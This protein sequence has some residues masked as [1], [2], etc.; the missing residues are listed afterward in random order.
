MFPK[1]IL[2]LLKYFDMWGFWTES[3]KDAVWKSFIRCFYTIHLI[4]VAASTFLIVHLTL[5]QH[6][7]PEWFLVNETVKQYVLSLTYWSILIES[8]FGRETQQK[9]WKLFHQIQAYNQQKISLK[10]YLFKFIKH[11]VENAIIQAMLI[12]HYHTNSMIFLVFVTVRV[13][14]FVLYQNRLYYYLFHLETIKS[15]IQILEND[16]KTLWKANQRMY[17]FYER[18]KQFRIKNC[19][20]D[21]I[22]KIRQQYQLIY[23]AVNCLNNC[24][25]G[26]PT[27]FFAFYNVFT[28]VNWATQSFNELS[29]LAIG[30]NLFIFVCLT[31]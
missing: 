8:F 15:T 7:Y 24:L 9:F 31:P 19:Y 2:I 11:I 23:D 6:H 13:T 12:N 25:F 5:S 3:T 10:M 17:A 1:S 30:L 28:L 20:F 18:K 21:K 22:R 16:V 27:I 29:L 14:L 26:F 4:I